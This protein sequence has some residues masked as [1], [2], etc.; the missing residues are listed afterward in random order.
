MFINTVYLKQK[1]I[2]LSGWAKKLSSK[3]LFRS[4]PN[5]DGFTHFI[6]HKVVYIATQ[7]RCDGMFSNHFTTDFSQNAPEKKCLKIG[8]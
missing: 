8:Q 3:L 7:L 6:F 5:T 2:Q 1:I 4:S